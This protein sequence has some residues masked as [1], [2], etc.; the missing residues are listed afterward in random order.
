MTKV[1][2]TEQLWRLTNLLLT[3]Q[4][5]GANHAHSVSATL[6]LQ[7]ADDDLICMLFVAALSGEGPTV[8]N[9]V[10]L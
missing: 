2:Q 7:L 9:V 5:L 10:A 4:S 3:N 6:L 1:T 8:T